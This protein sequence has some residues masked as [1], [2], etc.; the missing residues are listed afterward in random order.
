MEKISQRTG[1]Q[2]D[3]ME[4]ILEE[5]RQRISQS[6]E[7]DRNNVRELAE[8]ESTTIIV[9]AREEADKIV[10]ETRKQANI[11]KDNYRNH[12]V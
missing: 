5:F 1:I 9:R 10:T 6:M 8:Q 2:M 12:S 11:Y 3:G 7:K 4:G